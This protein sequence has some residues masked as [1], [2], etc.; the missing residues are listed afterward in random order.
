MPPTWTRY[1]NK[2][3]QRYSKSQQ[4]GIHEFNYDRL[5]SGFVIIVFIPACMPSSNYDDHFRLH[6]LLFYNPRDCG[7]PVTC[8]YY[9]CLKVLKRRMIIRV[10]LSLHLCDVYLTSINQL[11]IKIF[12]LKKI[13]VRNSSIF[14]AHFVSVL[15]FE[16]N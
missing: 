7:K 14:A 3:E 12:S 11:A 9:K 4:K 16:N 13:I 15:H 2:S 6:T 5:R 10:W 1:S 8:I